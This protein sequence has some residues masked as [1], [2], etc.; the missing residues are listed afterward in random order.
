MPTTSGD[1]TGLEPWTPVKIK[2]TSAT[3]RAA[4][5]KCRRQWFLT[6]V[7]RLQ[8]QDDNLNFWL[9]ELVHTGLQFYYERIKEGQGHAAAAEFALD[10]YERAFDEAV[11]RVKAGPLG[12]IWGEA[13]PMYQELGELGFG[14]LQGYFERE[15]REPIGDEV[16][17]VEVR[18]YVPIR[19]PKGRR[20]GTLAVRTDLVV[21]RY[22]H[23]AAVDHKTATQHLSP[24][25]LDIDDQLTAE[26]YVVWQ[27]LGE[28]PEEAVYNSLA[29]KIP[30]PPERLKDGKGGVPRFSQR[31]DAPTTA[32]L[33]RRTLAEH[34][35]T[36]E[37][38]EDILAHLDERE[39]ADDTPFFYRETTFRTPG[40]IA[41]FEANLYQEF[42]DMRE[43]AA[44][45]ERAYPNPSPFA[46]PTCPV[47]QVCMA[48][49]DG[50]DAGHLIRSGYTV[51]E[52]RY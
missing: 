7:H 46:C 38:Y 33:Y 21:R 5:R 49:M 22:G 16:V 39:A 12:I 1:P 10:A 51:G 26:T 36:E 31:K 44:H 40:Q 37:G 45:P 50:S 30:A 24:A 4:F 2:G 35:L 9:G 28:W 42:R 25:M 8:T 17:E 13:G 6:Q 20:I 41:A 19:S 3:E 32:A 34:G 18:R 15:A 11:A 43:V 27:V 52:P 48:M 47:R 14:M 23:L 29:K